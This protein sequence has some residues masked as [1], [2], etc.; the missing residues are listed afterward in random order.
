MKRQ[1]LEI[2]V[3]FLLYSVG[4]VDPFTFD[5]SSEEKALIVDGYISNIPFSDGAL[6]K[7]DPRFFEVNLKFSSGVKNRPD[8]PVENARLQVVSKDGEHWD[9]EEVEPGLYRLYFENF[10]AESNKE[11][12]I[13]IELSN[14]DIYESEFESAPIYND[15]ADFY[16]K[17]EEKLAY[18]R[19]AGETLIRTQ[20]GIQFYGR[21]PETSKNTNEVNY[22]WDYTTTYGA[23]AWGLRPEEINYKCWIISPMFYKERKVVKDVP[24]GP[25]H[26]LFFLETNSQYIH[27]DFSVLFKQMIMTELYYQFWVDLENQEKQEELFAPP[28]YNL[29]TNLRAVNHDKPVYGYFGVVSENFYRWF[30]SKDEISYYIVYPEEL[31]RCGAPPGPEC[32]DCRLIGRAIR[33]TITNTEPNWWER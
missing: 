25:E 14:G 1:H 18:E 21:V 12:Q 33:S 9:Y 10:M 32:F 6:Y 24:G 4:C 28:P 8:E 30:F 5:T 20:T 22:K 23:I 29:V 15:I 13:Y 3:F 27:E 16:F 2:F 19:I 7:M 31:Q 17:E 11:Y 26:E